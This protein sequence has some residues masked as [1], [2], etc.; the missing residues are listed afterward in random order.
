MNLNNLGRTFLVE[1]CERVAISSLLRE[2]K[3][4][5]KETILRSQFEIINIDVRLTTSWTGNQGI[6][7]WFLC[8]LCERRAGVLFR[9]PMQKRVGCRKCL[10]LEYRKQRYKGMVEISI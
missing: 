7:L 6:R 5:L 3:A 1:E 10:N 4:K 9:H 2:Y 8:P